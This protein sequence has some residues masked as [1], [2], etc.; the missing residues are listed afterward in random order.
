MTREILDSDIEFA[1]RLLG[2]GRVD[3]EI[4]IALS[5][6]GIEASEAA[7]LVTDL[8]TG[9]RLRPKMIL[10]PKRDGLRK[11]RGS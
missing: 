4:L 10:L 5:L 8:R 11:M 7:K 6:R 1:R 2:E 9:R 3:G